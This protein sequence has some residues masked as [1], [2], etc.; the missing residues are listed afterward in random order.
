M[1]A[2]G[3]PRLQ[4]AQRN[5]ILAIVAAT[6]V[7]AAF[8]VFARAQAIER[9]MTVS[10]VDEAGAVVRD[11]GPADFIV[12]EDNVSRE[13]LRV[14]PAT[15]PMDVAVLVDTSAASRNNIAHFRTALP[16][17]VTALTN[18]NASGLKN[19]VAIVATGER[20]TII[21]DYTSSVIELQKGISRLWAMNDTG[22]YLLDAVLETVQGFKKHESRRPVIVAI[23][24]EGREFSYRQY[25]QVLGPLRDSGAAFHAIAIGTPRDIATDEGRSRHIVLDEGTRDTGGR[26]TQLLTPMA[27][28]GSLGQ[29]AD[30]LTHQYLVVYAHPDSLIPPERVT[31]AA[32][33]PGLTA[34]GTLVKDKIPQGRP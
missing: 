19:R 17:F 3:P 1:A 5:L 11:L 14:V 33:K 23:T 28:A 12:R 20:P 24:Q 15:E 6:A 4:S 7:F 34:R 9:A 25:D 21:T 27:L 10:V 2:P 8:A 31:V 16:P 29:L 18:P 26:R 30:E 32:K 22:S 13:I